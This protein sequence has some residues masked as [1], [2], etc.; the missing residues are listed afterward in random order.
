MCEQKNFKFGLQVN[1]RTDRITFQQ[2][3]P[4]HPPLPTTIE[5][6]TTVL[7]LYRTA[8][9]HYTVQSGIVNCD[10]ALS[11]TFSLSIVV[12]RSLNKRVEAADVLRTLN[13]K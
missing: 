2:Q 9:P 4:M 10:V 7:P 3:L 8:S 12:L 1:K 6:R 5:T 11:L 13:F